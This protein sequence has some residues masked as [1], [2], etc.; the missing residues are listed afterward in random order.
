MKIKIIMFL[1]L[2]MREFYSSPGRIA[3]IFVSNFDELAKLCFKDVMSNVQKW[4][5]GAVKGEAHV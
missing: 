1:I 4:E 2:G 3:R 5:N